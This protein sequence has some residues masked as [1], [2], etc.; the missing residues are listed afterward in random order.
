M[1]RAD[2]IYGL[3]EHDVSYNANFAGEKIGLSAENTH[4]GNLSV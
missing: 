4:F 2:G 1:G 3:Q